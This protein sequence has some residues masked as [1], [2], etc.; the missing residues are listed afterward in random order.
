MVA[1]PTCPAD[2]LHIRPDKARQPDG[3]FRRTLLSTTVCNTPEADKVAANAERSGGWPVIIAAAE[4]NRAG[5]DWRP[6][7]ATARQRLADEAN[8]QRNQH[9]PRLQARADTPGA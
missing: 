8:R 6:T 5:L 2:A 4:A 7:A 9:V 1:H 3:S